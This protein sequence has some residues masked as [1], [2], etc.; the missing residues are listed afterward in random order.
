M[1][2]TD[3]CTSEQRLSPEKHQD[4]VDKIDYGNNA[5]IPVTSSCTGHEGL[6]SGGKRCGQPDKVISFCRQID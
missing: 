6:G 2:G 5:W 3:R 4:R 1:L